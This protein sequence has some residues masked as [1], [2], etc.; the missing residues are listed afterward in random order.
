MHTAAILETNMTVNA[1]QNKQ[2]QHK[3]RQHTRSVANDRYIESPVKSTCRISVNKISPC[4]TSRNFVSVICPSVVA[5]A[6]WPTSSEKMVVLVLD[7]REGPAHT[8]IS[9]TRPTYVTVIALTG[10]R[11][12]RHA[13]QRL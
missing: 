7:R 10:F 3:R 2:Q 6:G 5:L 12:N 4:S 13:N 9:T 1:S 8:F 11:F